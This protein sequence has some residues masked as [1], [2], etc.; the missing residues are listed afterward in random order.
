M[1]KGGT[2]GRFCVSLA[3][4]IARLGFGESIALVWWLDFFIQGFPEGVPMPE[5]SPNLLNWL[6]IGQNVHNIL[7][8][9]KCIPQ[10]FVAKEWE[11][12]RTVNLLE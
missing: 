2:G 10:Y 4:A 9:V 12:S 7:E 1:F 11:S 5:G 8:F 3:A 6:D